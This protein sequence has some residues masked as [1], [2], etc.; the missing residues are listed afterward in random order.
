MKF[1]STAEHNS[2][3]GLCLALTQR[4]D[5]SCE[6]HSS[7]L[8]CKIA[9]LLGPSSTTYSIVTNVALHVHYLDGSSYKRTHIEHFTQHHKQGGWTSFKDV[10]I[11]KKGP[12]G[13]AISV[14]ASPVLRIGVATLFRISKKE[15]QI[16]R[17]P[18]CNLLTGDLCDLM[19]KLRTHYCF[20]KHN[21]FELIK[22]RYTAI[23][24][25]KLR[26]R[27][28]TI[29]EGESNFEEGRAPETLMH[30]TSKYKTNFREKN[31]QL[32]A[33]KLPLDA[34]NHRQVS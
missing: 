29:A 22:F 1:V 28:E 10:S 19:V 4:I 11:L 32:R 24:W 33:W 15:L 34:E 9:S 23:C 2:Q 27:Q 16:S 31:G 18:W 5:C 3:H 17:I 13:Q 12:K 8:E 20:S 14:I 25:W 21:T 26:L 30:Q 6:F 7:C